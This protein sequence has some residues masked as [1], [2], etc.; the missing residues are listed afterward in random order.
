MF[1]DIKSPIALD[2][3][4]A[5]LI[6]SPDFVG[7]N[8]AY[9]TLAGSHAYGTYMEDSD[10]D[11]MGFCVPPKEI[12]FPHT[13]GYIWG[14]GTK[15]TQFNQNQD[16]NIEYGNDIIDLTIYSIVRFCDLAMD[17]N[18][19]VIELLFTPDECRTY[20]S[21]VG[22]VIWDGRHKFLNKKSFHRFMGFAHSMLNKLKKR[23][24]SPERLAKYAYHGARL[25][26]EAE[27]I[28][29][30]GQLRLRR[31][32]ATDYLMRIRNMD[33]PSKEVEEFIE[34]KEVELQELYENSNAV[35]W[36]PDEAA[37]KELLLNALE[38]HWGDLEGCV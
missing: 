20:M 14:F 24:R 10:I 9:E 36:A 7:P 16:H 28:L 22:K 19:N 35:P 21:D 26:F 13:Q 25:A 32:E 3:Q 4:I 2:L 27:D 17:N 29:K 30:H 33:V 12:V 5:D 34:S 8:M 31:E 6:E 18:P 38:E 11:V 15:P 1:S 37:V 23:D